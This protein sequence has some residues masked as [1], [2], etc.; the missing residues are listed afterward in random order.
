MLVNPKKCRGELPIGV[1]RIKKTGKYRALVCLDRKRLHL[2][3]F[4]TALEAFEAY[5]TAKEGHIKI[6]ANR[7][8]EKLDPRVYEALIN[9]K[10]EITDQRGER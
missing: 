2:G 3:H 10:I 4:D 5:K 1:D 7:Y 6:M 9:W 8:K